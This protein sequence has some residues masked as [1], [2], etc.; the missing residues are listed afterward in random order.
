MAQPG[1]AIF[2]HLSMLRTWIENDPAFPFH[3]SESHPSFPSYIKS[4]Y[5][6]CSFL[7]G[8]N[9]TKVSLTQSFYLK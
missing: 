5:N 3:L 7:L 6:R 8:T 4:P 2:I 1:K 9:S